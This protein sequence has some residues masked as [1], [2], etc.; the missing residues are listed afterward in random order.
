MSPENTI[1]MN[2]VT[3]DFDG[4]FVIR[5]K[6]IKNDKRE[7]ELRHMQKSY[8]NSFEKNTYRPHLHQS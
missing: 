4:V 6:I 1:V 5:K 2:S 7:N 3:L 8:G